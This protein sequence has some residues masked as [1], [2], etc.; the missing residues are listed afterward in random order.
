M[1]STR[2]ILS[3]RIIYPRI[4]YPCPLSGAETASKKCGGAR[5]KGK[6]KGKGKGTWIEYPDTGYF[7]PRIF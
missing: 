6:G 3:H 7:T 1:S 5:G 4:L 2:N